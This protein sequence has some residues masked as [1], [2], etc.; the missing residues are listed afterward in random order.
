MKTEFMSN[1]LKCGHIIQAVLMCPERYANRI[2]W[3]K[4]IVRP[5]EFLFD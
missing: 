1:P 2:G 3:N 5:A 4:V